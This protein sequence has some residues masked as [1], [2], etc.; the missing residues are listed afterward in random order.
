MSIN[1]WVGIGRL[2]A[3]PT[4]RYTPAGVAVTTFNLAVD[5]GYGEKKQTAFIPIV[6][7]RQLAEITANHLSKGSQCAIEGHIST[8]SYDNKEGHKVF[9]VEVVAD[10]VQFLDTKKTENNQ[11]KK[12]ND[13]FA[14]DSR[15]IDINSED[16]PF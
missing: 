11:D 3:D 9:V 1:K 13:P 14:H 16:L 7:W 6:A 2:T 12:S 5:N 8:R 15:T 4:L 10:N